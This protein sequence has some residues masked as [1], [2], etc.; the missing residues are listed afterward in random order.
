MSSGGGQAQ[1]MK[2]VL[3]MEASLNFILSG[4]GRLWRVFVVVC[5]FNEERNGYIKNVHS[6]KK[7]K[8]INKYIRGQL[9]LR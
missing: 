5:L 7:I 4:M 8:I 2:S 6:K 3:A 9:S 1:M